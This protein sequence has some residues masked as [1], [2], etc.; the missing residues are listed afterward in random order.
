MRGIELPN[1]RERFVQKG[2]WEFQ[3]MRPTMRMLPSFPPFFVLFF[4]LDSAS[5]LQSKPPSSFLLFFTLPLPSS[6][7]ALPN[8][9]NKTSLSRSPPAFSSSC[10]YRRLMSSSII[11]ISWHSSP[12]FGY[13]FFF[14]S[15]LSTYQ[16]EQRKKKQCDC[17]N[18]YNIKRLARSGD[19]G[20]WRSLGSLLLLFVC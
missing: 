8:K 4:L 19:N 10:V 3:A 2:V 9:R 20:W 7:E 18:K 17:T 12:F 6:Y 16:H 14:L 5:I 1:Y 15:L 13:L 11:L